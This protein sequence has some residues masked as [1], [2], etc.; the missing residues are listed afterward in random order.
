MWPQEIYKTFLNKG[1]WES[2][3]GPER[4]SEVFADG[5]IWHKKTSE[6][7]P[8]IEKEKSILR[9]STKRIIHSAKTIQK[10]GHCKIA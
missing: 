10:T 1:R 7:L 6:I 9:T 5:W 2:L 4:D 3:S 8:S